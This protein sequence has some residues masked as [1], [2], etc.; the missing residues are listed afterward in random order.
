MSIYYA[1][2]C[3]RCLHIITHLIFMCLQTVCFFFHICGNGNSKKLI[4][5]PEV[6]SDQGV[7]KETKVGFVQLQRLCSFHFAMLALKKQKPLN[8][9]HYR[10]ILL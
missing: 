9:L 7:T 2:H 10:Y 4:N 8:Y 1:R 3:A 5:L 6:T